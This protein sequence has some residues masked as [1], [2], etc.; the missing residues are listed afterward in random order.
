MDLYN[1][2]DGNSIIQVSLTVLYF[3]LNCFILEY[4]SVIWNRHQASLINKIE[5]V[6]NKRLCVLAYETN[7]IDTYFEQLQHNILISVT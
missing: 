3:S 5:R 1:A 4:G 7:K 6:Q 2:T